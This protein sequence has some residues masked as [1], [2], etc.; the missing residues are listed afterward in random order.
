MVGEV[1]ANSVFSFLI[2]GEAIDLDSFCGNFI[3]ECEKTEETLMNTWLNDIVGNRGQC[4]FVLVCTY[5]KCLYLRFVCIS[6]I[7]SFLTFLLLS[8]GFLKYVLG[9]TKFY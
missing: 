7:S 6:I 5:S 4:C 9:Y 1:V 3:S 8:W 2:S